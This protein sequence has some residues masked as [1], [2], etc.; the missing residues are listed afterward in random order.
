MQPDTWSRPDWLQTL[1][2]PPGCT[3]LELADRNDG[4]PALPRRYHGDDEPYER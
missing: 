2:I 1:V 3:R 4:I